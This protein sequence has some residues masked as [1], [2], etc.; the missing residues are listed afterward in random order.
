MDAL[1]CVTASG[2]GKVQIARVQASAPPIRPVA[3]HC[4]PGRCHRTI[5]LGSTAGS[6]LKCT[7]PKRCPPPPTQCHSPAKPHAFR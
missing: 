3:R 5:L 7:L 4:N 1:A 2:A 6:A